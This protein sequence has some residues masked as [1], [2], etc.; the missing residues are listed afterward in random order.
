[1]FNLI[2]KRIPFGK[3]KGR[4]MK[5]LPTKYLKWLVKNLQSTNF[6]EYVD[7][8]QIILDDETKQQNLDDLAD[9][10]LKEHR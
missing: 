3:Y 8:A 7:I 4:R 9:K 1:M 2:E 10:F 6:Q 5:T